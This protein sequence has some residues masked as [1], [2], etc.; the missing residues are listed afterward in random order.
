M[1]KITYKDYYSAA[2]TQHNTGDI[3]KNLPSMGLLKRKH[4]SGIIITPACDLQQAKAETLTYLPIISIKEYLSSR[5]FYPYV[6]KKLLSLSNTYQDTTIQSLLSKNSLPT[7]TDLQ[8][9]ID[10]Y[11]IKKEDKNGVIKKIK[12]GLIW[13]KHI[14]CSESYEVNENIVK[15]TI[16]EKELLSLKTEFVRNSHSSDLHFLPKDEQDIE[17][18]AI[19]NHSLVLF[20]YPITVPIEILD[21]VNN[22]YVAGWQKK[23]NEISAVFAVAKEFTVPPLKIYRLNNSFLSDLLTRFAGLYIRIGSPDFDEPTISKLSTE[24]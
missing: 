4:Y 11:K 20:R 9:V 2:L 8:F 14:A 12:N 5:P 22:Y 18:S 1:K 13:A 16:S 23:M 24:I 10:E 7:P 15:E 19:I 17:W 21:L 6:F 3:W